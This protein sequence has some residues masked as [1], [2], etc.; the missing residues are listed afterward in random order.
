MMEVDQKTEAVNGHENEDKNN[1][2]NKDNKQKTTKK[3]ENLGK[4]QKSIKTDAKAGIPVK[5]LS[6]LGNTCFFNSVIQVR[7]AESVYRIVPGTIMFVKKNAMK[8]GAHELPL[9]C[10]RDF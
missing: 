7:E 5:G 6:N 4:S 2:E 9:G 1:K 10:A 8:C 3:E